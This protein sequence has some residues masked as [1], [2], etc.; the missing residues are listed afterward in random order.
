M[1]KYL[2][3]PALI[4]MIFVTNFAAAQNYALPVLGS[5][6]SSCSGLHMPEYFNGQDD[7][8]ALTNYAKSDSTSCELGAVVVT[9]ESVIVCSVAPQGNNGATLYFHSGGVIITS[10]AF[11]SG[12]T[13]TTFDS[14]DCGIVS[15]RVVNQQSAVNEEMDVLRLTLLQIQ[16]ALTR[17]H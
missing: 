8:W 5:E 16:K 3:I 6:T 17:T 11:S 10:I 12:I 7:H 9:E 13:K 1:K 14:H 2:A 15:L 4:V